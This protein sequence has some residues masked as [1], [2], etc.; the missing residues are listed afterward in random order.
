MEGGGVQS[1]GQSPFS[2]LTL[3]QPF[4]VWIFLTSKFGLKIFCLI[5]YSEILE[6]EELGGGQGDLRGISW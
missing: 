2:P 6:K 1:Q 5:K 3:L 4:Q